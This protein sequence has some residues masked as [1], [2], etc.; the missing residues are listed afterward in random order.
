MLAWNGLEYTGS[1]APPSTGMFADT[2]DELRKL[3]EAGELPADLDPACLVVMLMAMTMAPTTLPH[4]VESTCGVDPRSPE[5]LDRFADQVAV[6][7]R[8]LGLG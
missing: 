1:D 8:H 3:Q 5:F 4:V 2:I 6:L 7:A